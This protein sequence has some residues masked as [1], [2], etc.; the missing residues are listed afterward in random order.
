MAACQRSGGAHSPFLS[1]SLSLLPSFSLACLSA[2]RSWPTA[3]SGMRRWGTSQ[4]FP[5]PPLTPSVCP[6]LPHAGLVS[7][8]AAPLSA[9]RHRGELGPEAGVHTDHPAGGRPGWQ[10]PE[11]P[12][13]GCRAEGG[14]GLGGRDGISLSLFSLGCE[15]KQQMAEPAVSRPPLSV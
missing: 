2:M 6:P 13:P 14:C 4:G 1:L 7:A 5:Q 8:V 12:G 9:G 3:V 10:H 15:A 11:G